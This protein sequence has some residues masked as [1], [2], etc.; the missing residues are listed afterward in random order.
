MEP[1]LIKIDE[2]T[3]K[4]ILEYFSQCSK[5]DSF[6]QINPE[7]NS[8]PKISIIIPIFN[9]EKN[10][11]P[12]IRSIQ[13]QTLQEIEILCIND[14]SNDN[15]LNILEKLKKEDTR[16]TILTNK[17]QRGDLFNLINI[18]LRIKTP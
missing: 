3:K 2:E 17:I 18:F 9:E 16:I 15:T 4:P 6:S 10:I 12:T 14:N 1:S 5:Q 8:Q 7:K 13:N 11:I